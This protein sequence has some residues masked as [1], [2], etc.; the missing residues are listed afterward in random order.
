LRGSKNALKE[1][2]F[3]EAWPARVGHV[4]GFI[5]YAVFLPRLSHAAAVSGTKNLL[6]RPHAGQK[7]GAAC[8]K[9][10]VGPV[11]AAG[12]LA[13]I[14]AHAFVWVLEGWGGLI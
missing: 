10:C 1:S 6:A 11:D 4:L 13:G 12:G 5:Q 2:A 3:S 7:Q 9:G 8:G 14:S